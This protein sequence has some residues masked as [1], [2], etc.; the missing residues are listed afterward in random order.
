[1]VLCNVRWSCDE[2]SGNRNCQNLGKQMEY[3]YVIARNLCNDYFRSGKRN[4]IPTENQMEEEDIC[5]VWNLRQII[6]MEK[7]LINF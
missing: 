2:N 5:G 4:E 6:D 7:R 3:L 1:M